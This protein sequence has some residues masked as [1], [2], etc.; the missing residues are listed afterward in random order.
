MLSQYDRLQDPNADPVVIATLLLVV[1]ITVRQAPH[2]TSGPAAESIRD[3]SAFIHICAIASNALLIL[4]KPLQ[5]VWKVPLFLRL[6]AY[7][8][9]VSHGQNTP[10]ACAEV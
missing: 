2:D 4:T 10:P 1:A 3:A 7:L 8:L 9:S 6:Q 5:E